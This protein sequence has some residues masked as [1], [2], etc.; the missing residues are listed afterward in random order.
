M[1]SFEKKFDQLSPEL[2]KKVLIYMDLLTGSRQKEELDFRWEG[3]LEDYKGKYTS[4][5]LQK[6][7][8]DWF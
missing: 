1:S 7:A 3:A 5:Q 2:Q 6:K 8:L 4:V